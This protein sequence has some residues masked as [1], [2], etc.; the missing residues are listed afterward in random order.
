MF[1]VDYN[2]P[3]HQQWA[4]TGVPVNLLGY[5]GLDLRWAANGGDHRNYVLTNALGAQMDQSAWAG[6]TTKWQQG[7]T[8]NTYY[9]YGTGERYNMV[10]CVRD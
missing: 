5:W 7:S 2:I 4:P 8:W 10:R 1:A 9:S 6:I 3:S